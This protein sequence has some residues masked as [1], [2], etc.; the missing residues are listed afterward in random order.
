MRTGQLAKRSRK[1]SKCC[2]RAGGRHQHGNLC[3]WF[4]TA[5]KAARIATSVLPKPTSPHRG[6]S[7]HGQ[8]L[9][10]I[11][12]YR[13]NRLRLVRR[14]FK[15][16]AVAKTADTCSRS[17]LKAKQLRR[18]LGINIQQLCRN[19]AHLQRL[20]VG[21]ATRHRRQSLC[22]GAHLFCATCIAG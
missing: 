20:S 16:E 5:R 18:A 17:C 6:S 2:A 11:A 1:L 19:I 10:H 14:G 4:S 21:I 8:R 22:S 12:E 13:V 9:T 3:L 15:R 7:V